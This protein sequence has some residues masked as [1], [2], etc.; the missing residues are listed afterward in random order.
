MSLL[1]NI[2]ILNY[3]SIISA[4][5]MLVNNSTI[6][7][8]SNLKKLFL[9]NA[10]KIGLMKCNKKRAYFKLKLNSY[11]FLFLN[12]A[13][14]KLFNERRSFLSKTTLPSAYIFECNTNALYFEQRA[15]S[16]KAFGESLSCGLND[17][18]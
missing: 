14:S 7:S 4:H 18:I 10:K 16:P 3:I 15:F 2:F 11:S 1:N 12:T 17:H 9:L 5:L 13:V 8:N 6:L